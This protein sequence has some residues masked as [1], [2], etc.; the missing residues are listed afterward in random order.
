MSLTAT[1]LLR[2]NVKAEQ[3]WADSALRNSLSKQSEAV[4]AVLA[5]QTAKFKEFERTDKNIKIGI[6]FIDPCG[7]DVRDCV[8]DNCDLVESELST[9]L[10]E[11]EPNICKEI[12]F[13]IN[14]DKLRNNMFN[15]EDLYAEGVKEKLGL[16]DEYLSVHV[17]ANLKTFA[18]V[19]AHAEPYTFNNVAKT[20]EV[21]S[22]KYNLSLIPQMIND[23]FMNKM[24]DSYFIDNG[25]LWSAFLL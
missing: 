1:E 9:G 22:A 10:L 24:G 14:E 19:N 8:T 23:G 17:L 11:L 13:A 25:S 12:G 5:N 21:P 20:T 4:K 18:G 2:L 6:A 15:L 16:L 3:T 7:G